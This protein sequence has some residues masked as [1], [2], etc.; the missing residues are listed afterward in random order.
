MSLASPSDI[1]VG[2]LSRITSKYSHF[3]GEPKRHNNAYVLPFLFLFYF[4]LFL[5]IYSHVHTGL[6][7]QDVSAP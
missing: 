2:G 6:P 1:G 3:G 4:I 7:F 5:F